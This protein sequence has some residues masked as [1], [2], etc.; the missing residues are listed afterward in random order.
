MT[1]GGK[2]V[3]LRSLIH[4]NIQKNGTVEE[5]APKG[6]GASR[7]G[8]GAFKAGTCCKVESIVSVD[9]R[10]Q[11]VLP[12]ELR[13]KARIRPGDKLALVSWEHEGTICC[14][15]LIKAEYLGQRVKDF[16]GPI[17]KEVVAG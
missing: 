8:L 4:Q 7:R 2:P 3:I 13:D 16:L 14:F 6:S 15:Y 9:Y 1:G 17:M 10:G 12:K 11:M 5:M